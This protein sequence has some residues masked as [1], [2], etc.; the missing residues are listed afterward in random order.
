VETGVVRVSRDRTAR[1]LSNS[2]LF[3]FVNVD[4]GL[5]PRDV[6][7]VHP[8]TYAEDARYLAARRNLRSLLDETTRGWLAGAPL[9]MA[10]A[11]PPSGPGA[12]GS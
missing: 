10:R 8:T 2:A 3:T 11:L 6:A 7:E 4:G 12:A 1:A 9:A 5:V